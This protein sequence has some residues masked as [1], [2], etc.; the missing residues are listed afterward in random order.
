[1]LTS[2]NLREMQHQVTEELT[3]SQQRARLTWVAGLFVLDDV[4]RQPT[5]VQ[6]RGPRLENKL[7]P[8]VEA[9]STAGF[10]QATLDLTQRVSLTAGLRGTRERKT[11]DNAG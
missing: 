8:K 11:I 1:D 4:D 6:L 7:D 3:V 5:L 10:G 9:N 2:V